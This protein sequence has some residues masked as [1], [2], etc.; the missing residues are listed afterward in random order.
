M[1]T[2]RC[3]T[4]ALRVLLDA[5]NASY[6]ARACLSGA[7]ISSKTPKILSH[8]AWCEPDD[9]LKRFI[10]I[11]PKNLVCE[12][13]IE[14]PSSFPFEKLVFHVVPTLCESQ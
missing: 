10:S 3:F 2:P 4:K 14:P 1:R 7:Y 11:L 5:G 12:S 13:R 8:K 6:L 9:E